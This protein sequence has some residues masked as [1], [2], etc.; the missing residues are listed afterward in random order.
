MLLYRPAGPAS[1]AFKFG[2]FLDAIIIDITRWPELLARWGS[3]QPCRSKF[4]VTLLIA[5]TLLGSMMRRAEY[6]LAI[7][8]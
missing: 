3:A 8:R 2:P 5:F 6:R 4:L 1:D 7:I